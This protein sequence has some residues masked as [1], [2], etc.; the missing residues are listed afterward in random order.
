[1]PT[2]SSTKDLLA[3]NGLGARHLAGDPDVHTPRA[4]PP[5]PLSSWAGS[6]ACRSR[7]DSALKSHAGPGGYQ[8]QAGR[9][10]CGECEFAL[11]W[12]VQCVQR[13]SHALESR[14]H[15]RGVRGNDVPRG[16]QLAPAPVPD[17]QSG[18]P[19]ASRADGECQSP[20][21][22]RLLLEIDRTGSTSAAAERCAIGQPPASMPLQ[23]PETA[24]GQRLTEFGLGGVAAAS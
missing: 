14:Q 15:P 19:R 5:G 20:L 17:H 10:A 2:S 3:D 13:R 8:D 9:M 7:P 22:L 23:A 21:R 4:R 18:W 11:A 12:C 16:G 6:G 24:I 1:M